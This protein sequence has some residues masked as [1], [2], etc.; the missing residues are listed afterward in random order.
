MFRVQPR[1]AADIAITP[2]NA[3]NRAEHR[4]RPAFAPDRLAYADVWYLMF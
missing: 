4:R 3:A 2:L 1:V